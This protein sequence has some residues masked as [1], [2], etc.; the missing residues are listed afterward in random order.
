M[1]RGSN[2][3]KIEHASRLISYI[4]NFIEEGQEF[5]RNL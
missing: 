1:L 2:A 3:K 4:S 5:G